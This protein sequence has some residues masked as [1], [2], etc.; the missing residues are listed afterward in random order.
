MFAGCNCSLWTAVSC[1][2]VLLCVIMVSAGS[3]CMQV[4]VWVCVCVCVLSSHIIHCSTMSWFHI[5][6]LE[7]PGIIMLDFLSVYLFLCL[8]LSL[9]LSFSLPILPFFKL[10]FLNNKHFVHV[11]LSFPTPSPKTNL[12]Y[13]P[14]LA[15]N[16]K[17][18]VAV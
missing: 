11:P 17:L 9:S 7:S 12:P 8:L 10:F 2:F 18:H 1:V 4:Q 15:Y 16:V 5:S 14:K 6:A 13:R 3:L